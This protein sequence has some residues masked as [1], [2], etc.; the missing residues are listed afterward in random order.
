MHQKWQARAGKT[1]SE[2]E[3]NRYV[4]QRITVPMILTGLLT[5][6]ILRDIEDGAPIE[7]EHSLGDLVRRGNRVRRAD[8]SLRRLVSRRLKA[9]ASRRHRAKAATARA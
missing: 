8:R 7:A 3:W 6:S 1:G 4:L 2:Y 5:A 9:S